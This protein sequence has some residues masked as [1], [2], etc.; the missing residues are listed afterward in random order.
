M[1]EYMNKCLKCSLIHVIKRCI[2]NNKFLTCLLIS[3]QKCQHIDV[4][5]INCVLIILVMENFN[6]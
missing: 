5:L 2:S 4:V 6:I 1:H 3:Y